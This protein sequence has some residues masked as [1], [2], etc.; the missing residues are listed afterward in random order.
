MA[1]GDYFTNNSLAVKLQDEEGLLYT[2][3]VEINSNTFTQANKSLPTRDR[4]NTWK[5]GLKAPE[6]AIGP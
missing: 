4:E 1:L 5:K 6:R 3:P 2:I